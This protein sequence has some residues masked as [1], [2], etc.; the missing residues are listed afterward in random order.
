MFSIQLIWKL[1]EKNTNAKCQ[2]P[3]NKSNKKYV[4]LLHRKLIIIT[5]ENLRK[6][7]EK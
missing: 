5:G 1:E 2:N 4:R 6:T 7:K 3:K